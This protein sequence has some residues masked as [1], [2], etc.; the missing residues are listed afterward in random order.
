MSFDFRQHPVH[1]TLKTFR[2]TL[3]GVE[4]DGLAEET[5]AA[6]ARLRDGVEYIASRLDRAVE[7]LVTPPMCDGLNQALSMARNE[8]VAFANDRNVQHLSTANV[9]LNE[10][11][12]HLLPI[13]IVLTGEDAEGIAKASVALAEKSTDMVGFLA[14]R[15]D[16]VMDRLQTIEEELEV[17]QARVGSLDEN[18]QR[19]R[20]DVEGFMATLQ[21]QFS[22]SEDRRRQ[23]FEQRLQEFQ[24]RYDEVQQRLE[25]NLTQVRTQAEDAQNAHEKA[26]TEESR[27]ILQE[28]ERLKAEATRLVG[29]IGNTGMTG[30]YKLAAEAEA[31]AANWWRRIALGFM[32]AAVLVLAYTLYETAS[33]SIGWETAL[34]RLI[35]AIL[36]G[37][38]GSYAALESAK[39]RN[40]ERRNRH[41]EQELAAIDPYL[42][43]FNP[44]TKARLKEQLAADVLGRIN[45]PRTESGVT[46]PQDKLIDLMQKIVE[47]ALKSG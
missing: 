15:I 39:H 38:P 18:I 9:K 5:C 33:N 47:K 25:A 4:C 7:S 6:I 1:E 44:S 32:T 36:I 46:L 45:P 42:A 35:A 20:G 34:I 24:K 29:V 10:A 2:E 19:V 16:P 12:N 13:P 14:A 37:V 41:I 30:E 21:S 23:D 43:S 26:L 17:S 27:A 40:E 8:I 28:L 3:D 31:H 11:L 22:E